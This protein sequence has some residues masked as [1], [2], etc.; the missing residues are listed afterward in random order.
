[1]TVSLAIIFGTI[2]LTHRLDQLTIQREKICSESNQVACRAL[3]DRLSNN[4]TRQQRF[5][6]G[7]SV[8][9][10]LKLEVPPRCPRP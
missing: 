6:L 5:E 10:V 3:F 8:A 7:C 9:V 2:A 1:M 4:I